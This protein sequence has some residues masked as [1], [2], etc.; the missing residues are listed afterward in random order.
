MLKRFNNWLALKV[1]GIVG[2][3]WAAY[4]FVTIALISVQAAFSSG[5]PILIVNWISQSFL[6][7]VLLPIILVGQNLLA[8]KH[9]ETQDDIRVIRQHVHW[10]RHQRDDDSSR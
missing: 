7:L 1:T 5:N 4:F 6:Q 10:L 9:S 8:S 2:S 3:M